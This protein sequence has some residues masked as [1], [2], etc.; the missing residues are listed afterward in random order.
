MCM[1]VSSWY[2]WYTLSLCIY[3]KNTYLCPAVRGAFGSVSSSI[4][5]IDN[6]MIRSDMSGIIP[7]IRDLLLNLA[8]YNN[9]EHFF[10][11]DSWEWEDI[12]TTWI[13]TFSGHTPLKRMTDQN[14]LVSAGE[15]QVS[16][17]KYIPCIQKMIREPKIFHDLYL[18]FIT[19]SKADKV[20]YRN[21]IDHFCYT[22]WYKDTEYK[23]NNTIHDNII[24]IIS[25][26]KTL[27]YIYF[28]GIS[29]TN[30]DKIFYMTYWKYKDQ[31]KRS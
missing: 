6:L 18:H 1:I 14:V 27:Q 16:A 24:S 26:Q 3:D 8:L 23:W 7:V 20:Q 15:E 28:Q 4:P 25:D 29:P 12:F 2:F 10:R 13:K 30:S 21:L 9:I 22:H 5:I 31:D 11:L 17:G 19:F